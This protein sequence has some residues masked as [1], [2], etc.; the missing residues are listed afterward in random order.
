MARL[1]IPGSDE[2]EWG[3]ILNEFLSQVHTT[4]GALKDDSI[5]EASLAPSVVE[6][7]NVVAGQQG[8]TGP[9]GATG[10]IGPQGPAGSAGANG[11]TGATGAQGAAGPSGAAGPAG[12]MGATGPAGV[13]GASGPAGSNGGTG[14]TGPAGASGSAG[15]TGAVGPSGPAGAGVPAAGTTGQLLAKASN[16][17]YAT[18]WIDAPHSRRERCGIGTGEYR[19]RSSAN[20]RYGAMDWRQYAA[21]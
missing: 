5:T 19:Q 14:A 18:A 6:K 8:A 13:T 7:L 1:P 4:S 16:T 21:Y 20:C 2:G 11:A 12:A 15:A 3:A 10:P 17:D 9:M